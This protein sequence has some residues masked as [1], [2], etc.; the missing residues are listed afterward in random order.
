M[1]DFGGGGGKVTLHSCLLGS[2][3]VCDVVWSFWYGDRGGGFVIRVLVAALPPV[4][5]AYHHIWPL[6]ICSLHIPTGSLSASPASLVSSLPAAL[7]RVGFLS[8]ISVFEL[9]INC[10]DFNY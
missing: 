4:L 10:Y 1:W 9:L 7:C 3:E 6:P 2:L 5:I 8:G